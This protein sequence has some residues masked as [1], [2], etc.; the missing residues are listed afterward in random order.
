MAKLVTAVIKPFKL[1]DVKGA[2]SALGIAGLTV[3]EVQ[4]YG[5]QKGHTEVYRG[6]EYQVDFVPKVKIE[7]AVDDIEAAKVV[8]ALVAAAR[9]GKI[10]D[11]KVWVTSIDEVVRVR[12]G[13]RGLDAL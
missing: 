1:E 2:L 10:G 5:R 11:G 6:A 4:G 3:S 12:T 9:T 7:V 13:E 8:D